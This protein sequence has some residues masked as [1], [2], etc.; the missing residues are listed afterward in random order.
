MTR[1]FSALIFLN[2]AV[3]ILSEKTKGLPSTSRK[4]L[5]LGHRCRSSLSITDDESVSYLLFNFGVVLGF[6]LSRNNS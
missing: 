6:A 5:Y 4:T 3:R 2:H 1:F